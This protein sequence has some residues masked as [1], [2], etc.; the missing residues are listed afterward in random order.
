MTAKSVNREVPRTS[1]R[2]SRL[3]LRAK[4]A[5]DLMT[6][7]VV[8]IPQSAPLH[9]A[10]AMLVDRKFSAA[11][12]IDDAGR[13]V[14]VL[15]MTDVVIHDRN[16]VGRARQVPEFYRNSD[17]QE[18][19]GEPARGFQV[20][21]ADRTPVRDLMTPVLFSVRPE[22]PAREVIEQMLELRVHRLFVID[23]DGVLVGVVSMSDVMRRLLE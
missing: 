18:A 20:E 16:T 3:V 7:Q 14:G 21:V 1:A 4:T 6:P 12:V 13:P 5:A 19:I 9:Q 10:V 2:D 15:S 22:T 8:S 17:L 11:P 23:S